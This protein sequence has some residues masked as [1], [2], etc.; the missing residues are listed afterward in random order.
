MT[1]AKAPILVVDTEGSGL[2][3]DDGARVSVISWAARDEHG[4]I[5]AGALPFG[6]GPLGQLFDVQEDAGYAK[7]E[8]TLKW[9]GRCRLIF[10]N[11]VHDIL[12]LNAGSIMG[13][14]GENFVEDLFW[15]TLV[16]QKHL[17]PLERGGLEDVCVRRLGI[18]PWKGRLT[19]WLEKTKPKKRHDLLPWSLVEPYAT[20][21]AVNTLLLYEDQV[22][23]ITR[24]GEGNLEIL[25]REM[26]L[27][28]TLCSMEMRGVGYAAEESAAAG[29]ELVKLAAAKVKVLPTTL[30][31]PTPAKICAYYYDDLGYRPTKI[32]TKTGQ[33]IRSAD[34]FSRQGLREQGA[35]FIDELDDWSSLETAYSMW[36]LPWA[37]ATGPDGRL[38][39]RVRQTRVSSGRLSG[40]RANLLAIPHDDE[41]LP[42][43]IPTVR[44]FIRPRPGKKLWEVDLSQAEV[45][46]GAVVTGCQPL[47]DAYAAK[48]DVY[49][50][51]AKQLFDVDP[52]PEHAKPKHGCPVCVEFN[53]YRQ[54]CKRLVLAAFYAAGAKTL[55]VQVKKFMK[56]DLPEARSREF[57]D[58]LFAQYPEFKKTERECMRFVE[59]NGYIDLALGEKRW[60]HSYEQTYKAMNQRIQGSVSVG[61]KVCMVE[62]ERDEPGALLLQTHDSLLLETE[63][64]DMPVRVGK[65]MESR[66]EEIFGLPFKADIKEWS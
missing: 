54:L 20:E 42:A 25:K 63:D 10:H 44:S 53:H 58:M 27:A 22:A 55:T 37:A 18:K 38:R 65:T 6:Q 29:R 66:F 45:R 47:I 41:A 52:C 60:F 49:A 56:L 13:Y 59:K 57:L 1:E 14:D 61:M 23:R 3:P 31:P 46:V 30:Q 16:A 50:L 24:G 11:A 62:V 15:D 21:D 4:E 51:T 8:H 34:E 26:A 19:A 12:E 28:R 9:L 40:E 36:Y 35:P 48:Y 64:D 43:D 39:M 5:E 17:D 32:D 7:W 2:Y 33:P